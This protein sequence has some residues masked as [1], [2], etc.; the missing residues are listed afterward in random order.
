MPRAAKPGQSS[1]ELR[2]LGTVD[3]LAV[4]EH[5]ADGLIEAVPDAALLCAKIDERDR[6]GASHRSP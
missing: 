4:R 2:D 6:H 3:V 5:P 1:F